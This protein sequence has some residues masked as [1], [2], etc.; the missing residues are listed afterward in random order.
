MA[1]NIIIFWKMTPCSLV[2]IYRI[3]GGTFGIYPEDGNITCRRNV[4][5]FIHSVFCFTI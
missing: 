1:M 3:F 5:L 2:E 4:A